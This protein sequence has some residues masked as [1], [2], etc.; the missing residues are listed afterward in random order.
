MPYMSHASRSYLYTYS[1]WSGHS[2]CEGS[3]PVGTSEEWSGA[4][5]RRDLVCVGLN[6]DSRIV[7]DAEK[8]VYDFESLASGRVVCSRNVHDSLVLAIRVISEESEDWYDAFGRDV[9][10]QLILVD[11]VLLDELGK[12]R[13]KVGAVFV[14]GS[15]HRFIL[16]GGVDAC[17]LQ[18]WRLS[19][20]WRDTCWPFAIPKKVGHLH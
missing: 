10:A 9:D 15:L 11:R 17:T 5:N 14:E 13:E 3:P 4:R 20:L 16:L 1:V 18:V 6:T 12:G 19:H 8:I 7:L 2:Y